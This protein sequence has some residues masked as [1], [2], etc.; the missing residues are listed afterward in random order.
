[1]NPQACHD[2]LK[3][4]GS[5]LHGSLT[6]LPTDLDASE[7]KYVISK[8]DWL[9]AAR[10]H[11]TIAAL[12]SGI[13]AAALA[14]S[15]KFHGVFAGCGQ[16]QAVADPTTLTTREAEEVL[17]R[18]FVDREEAKGQLAAH[19]PGIRNTLARQADSILEAPHRISTA[20]GVS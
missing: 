1:M 14:Y 12:S 4:L 8:L 9:V 20:Q 13:P 18:A 6:I 19:L 16:S 15:P 11:A 10:M 7:T 5:D 3:E 17:W 2:L